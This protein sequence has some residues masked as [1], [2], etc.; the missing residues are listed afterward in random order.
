MFLL[1]FT[2]KHKKP[3]VF[4]FFKVFMVEFKGSIS[5]NELIL[6][7]RPCSNSELVALVFVASISKTRPLVPESFYYVYN[8]IWTI[9][10]T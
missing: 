1:N 3:F 8:S 9:T 4:W 7:K 10:E 2:W 6:Q 5:K